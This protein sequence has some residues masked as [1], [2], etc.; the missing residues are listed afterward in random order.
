MN[1]DPNLSQRILIVALR[2][3]FHS[4]LNLFGLFSTQTYHLY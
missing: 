2:L 1:Y 3:R 4:H